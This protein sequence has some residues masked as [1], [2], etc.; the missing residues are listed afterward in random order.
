MDTH[1][2]IWN[3]S[4]NYKKWCDEIVPLTKSI[5]YVRPEKSN[6]SNYYHW[7]SLDKHSY[8]TITIIIFSYSM[9][10]I[11]DKMESSKINE[12]KNVEKIIRRF[13]SHKWIRRKN[14][15][16]SW[17]C[18]IISEPLN[19]WLVNSLFYFCIPFSSSIDF[20]WTIRIIKKSY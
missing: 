12:K 16:N 14:V 15:A 19:F 13:K 8:F 17:R 18:A 2:C 6:G 9:W 3:Q 10:K 20:E 7:Y 4:T 1:F 5:Q 11:G